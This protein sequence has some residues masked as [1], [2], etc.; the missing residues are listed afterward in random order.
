MIVMTNS[1][2]VIFMMSYYAFYHSML[3]GNVSV[4]CSFNFACYYPM[5]IETVQLPLL[6]GQTK[7]FPLFI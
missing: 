5:G 2:E 7:G 1:N 4:T 6:F 3:W